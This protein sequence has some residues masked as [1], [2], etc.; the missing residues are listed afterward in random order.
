[1]SDEKPFDF[2]PKRHR[3]DGNIS[4]SSSHVHN[5]NCR[6]EQVVSSGSADACASA[7]I[8]NALKYAA[9]RFPTRGNMTSALL[10][11]KVIF[12]QSIVPSEIF[13][14]ALF[15]LK[16]AF[17]RVLS[18]PESFIE[19]AVGKRGTFT[20]EDMNANLERGADTARRTRSEP[21]KIRPLRCCVKP[22]EVPDVEPCSR[23]TLASKLPHGACSCFSDESLDRKWT[24]LKRQETIEGKNNDKITIR[25]RTYEGTVRELIASVMAKAKPYL[26][27]KWLARFTRRQFHLDCDN[28]LGLCEA[29]LLAD[30]S[31]AMVLGS[32]YKS[33]CETDA[34]AN[35]YV[36]LVLYKKNGETKCDYVRFWASAAT[37]AEFHHKAMHVVAKHLKESGKV[38]GLRRLR[39][40]T[41]GHT[42]T[43]K[44]IYSR[45]ACHRVLIPCSAI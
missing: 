8:L 31:T 14:G 40:W 21:F 30:F 33:T 20:N 9:K 36:V 37:S 35:L 23:C 22:G 3:V 39:V 24:W 38:P 13:S 27:H 4:S 12:C 28:F 44:G 42:S 34:T 45:R 41:D 43:Y 19:F 32:G 11:A 26:H 17:Q 29:V 15:G 1:M 25:L 2:V 10:Q 7:Q 6:H 18:V 5:A 16:A